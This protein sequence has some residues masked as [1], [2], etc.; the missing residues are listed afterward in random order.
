MNRFVILAAILA[1][2]SGS[3][4]AEPVIDEGVVRAI[5][6]EMFQAVKEG[7]I[8]IVEKYYYPGSKIVLDMDPADD[9]GRSEIGYEEFLMLAEVGI[10]SMSGGEYMVEVTDVVVDEEKNQAT[11]EE[12]STAVT[13]MMGVMLT[14]SSVSTTLFGVVDGEI[15]VLA[16]EERLV[17]MDI[18]Q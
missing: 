13:E 11:I 6:A 1:I 16:S 7:D 10:E 12:S 9:A 18:S 14:Q 2:A 3:A 17:S 5:S 8:S 15:K 4:F